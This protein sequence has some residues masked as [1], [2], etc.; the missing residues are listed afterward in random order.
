MI[1][2]HTSSNQ[3]GGGYY[4]SGQGQGVN[5]DSPW[6]AMFQSQSF[7]G[8]WHQMPQ[9]SA[10][11]VTVSHTGAPSP[12][13]ANHVGDG[14]TTST[15]P[16]DDS[17]PNVASNAGGTT[18]IT[19]SHINITSLTSVHHVGDESSTSAYH[20]ESMSPAIVNTIGGI[21]NPRHLICKPKFLCRTCEVY[22]LTRLCPTIVK[23]PEAWGSPKGPLVFEASVVSPHRIS[24]FIDT[25]VMLPHSSPY[26][27]LVVEGEFPL[28]PL[29]CILFNLE[30]NK[31]SYQSHLWSILL[32]L[33]RVM[34]P[35][36]IS[37]TFLIPHLMKERDFFSP[38]VL[39][40]KS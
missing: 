15:S 6:P 24:P 12:T 39:S 4:L 20:V 5:Q 17:H 21:E 13:Y 23:I 1:P 28:S 9:L 3:L 30:L 14:S 16:V 19:T 8:P 33:Q 40:P 38:Q 36:I 27:T 31:L 37:S 35:S 10:S 2:I 7:P 18:L 29:P 25:M 22:H 26:L 32:S 11:P 34:C